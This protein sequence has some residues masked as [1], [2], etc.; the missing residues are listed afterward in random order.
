MSGI[1]ILDDGTEIYVKFSYSDGFHLRLTSKKIK[2][3]FIFIM[4]SIQYFSVVK[5]DQLSYLAIP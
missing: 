2:N 3:V 4:L 1:Q 5:I